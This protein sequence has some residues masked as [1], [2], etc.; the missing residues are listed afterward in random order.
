MKQLL[1]LIFFG[2][3]VTS[4]AQQFV[5]TPGGLKDASNKEN[6]FLVINIKG[7][8]AKELYDKSLEYIIKTYQNPDKVIK[9]KLD[10]EYL[11]YD[12]YVPNLLYIR[13]AGFKQFFSAS[14]SVVLNFK[15]GKIKYEITELEIK[16]VDTNSK[17]YFE[18]GGINWYIY[19]KN[20]LKRPEAKAD[21]EIFF[22]ALVK[23][24]LIYLNGESNSNDW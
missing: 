2:F 15:D 14:F 20:L 5:V 1:F 4:Y 13:N 11:R 24:F 16:H 17:L 10:G 23:T 22:N 3:Y 8:S 21:V 18:A 12:T 7:L 19:N 9:G 6:S